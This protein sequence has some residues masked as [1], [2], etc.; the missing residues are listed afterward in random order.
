MPPVPC[1]S[2]RWFIGATITEKESIGIQAVPVYTCEAFPG[3]IPEVIHV[4][5]NNHR[6]PVKGDQGIQYEKL[7]V[8]ETT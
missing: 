8:E 6:K 1:S 7:V 5:D 4:G 3:G 2:C